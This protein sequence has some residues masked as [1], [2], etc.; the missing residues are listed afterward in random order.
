[1]KNFHQSIEFRFVMG[2]HAHECYD[3]DSLRLSE[4]SRKLFL[5]NLLPDQYPANITPQ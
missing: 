2:Y 3:I 5:A 1:M 4:F